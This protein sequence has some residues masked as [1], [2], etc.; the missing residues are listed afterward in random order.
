M[1]F[2]DCGQLTDLSVDKADDGSSRMRN[3]CVECRK[4]SDITFD[5]RVIVTVNGRDEDAGIRNPKSL[6]KDPL[7]PKS[8]TARCE[9]CGATHLTQ[10]ANRQTGKR[11]L[12][13]GKCERIYK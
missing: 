12:V 9:N 6:A 2:C 3:F 7:I 4:Y 5:Q 10:M 13:C 8:S 11:I 1:H